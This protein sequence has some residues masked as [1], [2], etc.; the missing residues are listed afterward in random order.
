MRPPGPAQQRHPLAIGRGL[1]GMQ[2]A[3]RC[4]V[5]TLEGHP[6]GA[7][8]LRDADVCFW[9]SPEH[10]EEAC[11]TL[12]DYRSYFSVLSRGF[13]YIIGYYSL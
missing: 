4:S 10:E 6:C 9:H 5:R 11:K 13:I 12:P 1:V 2:L 7:T 3:R 8:P